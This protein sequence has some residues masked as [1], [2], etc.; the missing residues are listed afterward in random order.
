VSEKSMETA[1]DVAIEAP[2]APNHSAS[3]A[4]TGVPVLQDRLPALQC[5]GVRAEN[6]DSC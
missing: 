6:G 5:R 1:H 4:Q 3:Q 2:E